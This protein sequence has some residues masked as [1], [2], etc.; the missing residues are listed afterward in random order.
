MELFIDTADA[1]AVAELGK[2]LSIAGVTTNPTTMAQSGKSPDRVIGEMDAVL[3]PNQKLF[4][5]VVADGDVEAILED[6]RTIV[7]LR[8]N[9]YVKIPVTPAG[10]RAIKVAKAEGIGV[11][12]TA[13]YS[14]EQ[15]FLAA[16]NG[17]DYLSPYVNRMCNLGDGLRQMCELQRML[18]THRLCAKVCAASFKNVAQV[19]EVLLAG[20]AAVTVAPDVAWAMVRHPSTQIAVD[21][22]SATWKNKLGRLVF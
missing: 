12:A 21:E 11:L 17:A 18:E 22:F 4:V 5:Q 14:A 8:D 6:A 1:R 10:M 19:H 16:M 3:A 20:A 2:V 13:I 9:V 7:T 15:A